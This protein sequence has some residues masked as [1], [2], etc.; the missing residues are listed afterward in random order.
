MKEFIPLGRR[1]SEGV[2]DGH[3]EERSRAEK[4]RRRVRSKKETETADRRENY[5]RFRRVE[6][7]RFNRAVRSGGGQWE[8]TVRNVSRQLRV[9][10]SDRRRN[11]FNLIKF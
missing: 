7:V 1:V 5:R 3:L 6:L 4:F 10:E 2:C 8:S 9:L 11:Q